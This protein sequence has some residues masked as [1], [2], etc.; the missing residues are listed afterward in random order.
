MRPSLDHVRSRLSPASRDLLTAAIDEADARDEALWVVGGAA[1]DCALDIPVVDLD[2]ATDGDPLPLA[3]AVAERVDGVAEGWPRFGTASVS[4]NR[5]R[6]D[7]AALR[8][9]RYVRP[10]A[11]PTVRL[12]ASIE[13][14]LARRDFTVNAVALGITGRRAG[15]LVD[16]FGGLE[17]LAAR[18]LRVLHDR[19]FRDDAT[20]LWRGARYATRPRLR[21]DAATHR[22]I[23]DGAR[24]LSTISSD[25]LWA[26]FARTAAESRPGA[27]LRLLDDWGTLEGVDPAFRLTEASSRALR[28]LRGPVEPALLLALAL[29][30]LDERDA[31]ARRLGA[32]RDARTAVEEVARLLEAGSTPAAARPETLEALEQTSAP[33]RDAALRLDR[34][35]QRG[36][37]S[38]LRRW[39]RTRP[40][41]DAAALQ[42]LGVPRGPEVGE[43]LRRLRRERFSGNL[44]SV[45]AARR[46]VAAELIHDRVQSTAA[47]SEEPSR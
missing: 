36:L 16:P 27:V 15:E 40:H 26:E 1:R 2:L 6:L 38:G 44:R 10:G 17:D 47:S 32:P 20:R 24:W 13:E 14:D 3:R 30:P 25:R 23:E 4:A 31:I 43:W 29:A 34:E 41:L 22:L 11:L 28:G 9:E 8:T 39:E 35:R 45:A 46:F 33:A 5:E 19:S 7:L 18:R 12:G 21:P 37:Q 42:Q